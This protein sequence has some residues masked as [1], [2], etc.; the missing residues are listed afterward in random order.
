[1]KKKV[2][3]GILSVVLSAGVLMG[4]GSETKT[5]TDDGTE[6]TEEAAAEETETESANKDVTIGIS[7]FAEHGSLDNCRE[8][9][10]KGL[11]AEGY[12]EGDNLTIVVDNAQA[13]TGTA[14]TIA[15]NFVS[16]KVDMI[17]AIATPA[18]MSAYNSTKDADIPV[19][20]SAIS[21]PVAAGLANED[22]S[23][24]GNITGTSDALPV[25]E[26][27]KLIRKILPD[28]KSI[29]ILYTTSETNSEST[30]A[31]YKELAG[32]YDFTIVESGISTIADVPMAA[33][34][35]VGKV[36]CLTNLTDNTVVSAL[37]TVLDAANEKNIPVFGSE[38]E[39]VKSGCL[40]AMG[41]DYEKL[42]EQTGVMAAKILKGEAT[43][44]ETPYETISEA[45]GY[46]NNAVA[47]ELGITFA[48][49]DLDAAAEVFDEI[50]VE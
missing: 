16:K 1:M 36:D 31:E 47:A 29:G 21:D 27:L 19:V 46:F 2:L 18:A 4:C 30:I 40:A 48:Q 49:E 8:G 41:I 35:L 13:D 45:S 22:G 9:F 11:E 32:K 14:S 17:C 6:T 33:A 37:Q 23:S 43:A 24:I 10:I 7:Q 12:V 34:D 3:A 5:E 28:A 25:E 50:T 38:I 39:Q 44:E 20:Y 15:D 26:Q 42:G